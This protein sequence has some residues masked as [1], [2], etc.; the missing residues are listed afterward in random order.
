MG[1]IGYG[2][3][4]GKRGGEGEEEKGEEE[5]ETR[6]IGGRGSNEGY[7]KKRKWRRSVETYHKGNESGREEEE[8]EKK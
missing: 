6:G 2:E 4:K 8:E 3:E 1:R 5:W 7:G